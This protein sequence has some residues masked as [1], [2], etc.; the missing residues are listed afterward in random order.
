MTASM[1][2]HR[3]LRKSG[4]VKRAKPL[5]VMGG[6]SAGGGKPFGFDGRARKARTASR[7]AV[8]ALDASW[9]NGR[10]VMCQTRAHADR[11]KAVVGKNKAFKAEDR[12]TAALSREG[13]DEGGCHSAL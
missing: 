1:R 6:P 5:A 8:I 4:A 11:A 7:E 3:D 12:A 13:K 10:C 2:V 9:H